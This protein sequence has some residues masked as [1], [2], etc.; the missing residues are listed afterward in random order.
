M[1]YNTTAIPPRKDITGTT[2]LPCVYASPFT[3]GSSTDRHPVTRVKKIISMDQ[4][5]NTCSN[6]AA[7][8]ITVATV[9]LSLLRSLREPSE[10]NRLTRYI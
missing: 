9:R 3:L 2:Q 7:F 4:D 8:V 1:P 10:N 6:N 5:I